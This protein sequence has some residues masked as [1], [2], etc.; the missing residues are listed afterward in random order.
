MHWR[1]RIHNG[2][3]ALKGN[4]KRQAHKYGAGGGAPAVQDIQHIKQ[5]NVKNIK[6]AL[7]S[8]DSQ[9]FIC[10]E[11]EEIKK[12]T[13]PFNPPSSHQ[14]PSHVCISF[15]DK[16]GLSSSRRLFLLPPESPSGGRKGAKKNTQRRNG[17]FSPLAGL[18]LFPLFY[19]QLICVQ[20]VQ[21]HDFHM[22]Q[23][24]ETKRAAYSPAGP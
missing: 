23:P 13:P 10:K 1:R 15:M 4:A 8:E 20:E 6:M 16:V 7:C 14:S 19:S 11:E 5:E 12:S 2:V 9:S 21:T 24:S 22:V 3:W 18:L 17:D